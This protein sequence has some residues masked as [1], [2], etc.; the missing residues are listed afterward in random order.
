MNIR[1]PNNNYKPFIV[2]LFQIK[3]FGKV[4][5]FELDLTL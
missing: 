4:Y 3:L 2:K 5:I 1:T